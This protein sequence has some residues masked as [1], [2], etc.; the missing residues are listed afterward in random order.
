MADTISADPELSASY[1]GT[2]IS[3]EDPGYDEARAIYNGSIDRRPALIA[4][5]RGAADVIDI[6]DY[7]R[8]RGLPI[9]VRCGGHGV[10]GT[11]LVEGGVLIDLS[12]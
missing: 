9:S 6:L 11:S 3:P 7:A 12:A 10:A 2:T 4:R 8:G 1:Q 5:P